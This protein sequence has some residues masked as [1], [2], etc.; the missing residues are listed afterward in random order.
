MDACVPQH[1]EQNSLMCRDVIRVVSAPV[2]EVTV[3]PFM[4]RC[5]DNCDHMSE[6]TPDVFGLRLLTSRFPDVTMPEPCE[7]LC[8]RVGSCPCVKK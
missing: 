3:S 6:V 5:L 8:Y 1:F 2:V 7:G 4:L